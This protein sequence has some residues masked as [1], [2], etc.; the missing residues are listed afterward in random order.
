MAHRSASM[1]K[2]LVRNRHAKREL[3]EHASAERGRKDMASDQQRGVTGTPTLFINRRLHDGPDDLSGL[4]AASAERSRRGDA[5]TAEL[6]T[7]PEGGFN[8]SSNTS[9][10]EFGRPQPAIVRLAQSGEIVGTVL[11]VGCGTGENALYLSSLGHEVTAIDIA[12]EAIDKARRKSLQRGIRVNFRL[13]DALALPCLGL[14][15]D[16]VIDSG[17]FHVFSDEERVEFANNLGAVLM[18]GGRYFMLCMSER[19]T[20]EGPRQVTQAEIRDTFRNGWTINNIQETRF[21][22]L[23]HECGAWAW[24]ASISKNAAR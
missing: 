10:W 20:R 9:T 23:I 21:E 7:R 13:S 5:M 11:D 16:T 4:S 15:F 14:T 24:L 17:L 2:W 19:E 12:Q 6:T 1:G 22:T 18:P 8:Q 3:A